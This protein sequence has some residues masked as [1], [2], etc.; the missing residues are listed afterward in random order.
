MLQYYIG[1]SNLS[2]G[3]KTEAF[4]G[5]RVDKH[6]AQQGICRGMVICFDYC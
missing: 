1:L 6:K 2:S 5:S 3:Q 4:L